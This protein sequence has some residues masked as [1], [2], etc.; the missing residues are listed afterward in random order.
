MTTLKLTE[1]E[2]ALIEAKRVQ[3]EAKAKEEEARLEVKKNETIVKA[4]K[5]H[6]QKLDECIAQ[7]KA[8]E[9]YFADL[10]Q[11]DKGT[12]ILVK[13]PFSVETKASDYIN[14]EDVVWK[15]F[16]DVMVRMRVAHKSDS[17]IRVYVKKHITYPGS[18]FYGHSKDNGYKMVICGIGYDQANKYYKKAATVVERIDSY[19]AAEARKIEHAAK[20]KS[21]L[22]QGVDIL[23][24]SYPE[25]FV[26]TERAGRRDSSNKWIEWDQIVVTFPNGIKFNLTVSEIESAVVFGKAGILFP[27]GM[28][29]ES[30]MDVLKNV[31]A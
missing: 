28:K 11:E 22:Q 8:T 29:I 18:S 1:E 15:T 6:Q 21:L 9:T 19:I 31:V 5:Y 26:S 2:V 25:A 16:E 4:A 7:N 10:E 30:V 12:F 23:T 3:D 24:A 17:K 20:K 14:H 27:S 13:D